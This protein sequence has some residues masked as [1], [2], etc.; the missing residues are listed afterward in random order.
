MTKS[1]T[2]DYAKNMIT[3]TAKFHKAAGQIGTDA[4]NLM[5]ELRKLNMPIAVK[6]PAQKKSNTVTY[7]KMKKYISLMD[8]ADKYMAEFEA[9]IEESKATNKAY[10][11]VLSWFKKT[12]PR[13]GKQPERDAD[14]KIVNTPVNYDAESAA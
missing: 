4:Y 6:A 1:Y 9:V 7:A 8:E 11:Y 3:V 13:Y 12:F 10:A 14:L 5:A 2:I